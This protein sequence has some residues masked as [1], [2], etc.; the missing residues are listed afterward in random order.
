FLPT[1]CS[2]SLPKVRGGGPSSAAPAPAQPV[3]IPSSPLKVQEI[4]PE[5]TTR[6]ITKCSRKRLPETTPGPRKKAKV[7][8]RHKSHHEVESLKIQAVKGKGST[9]PVDEA[10]TPRSRRPKLVRELCNAQ[11]GVDG[12]DYHVVRMSS[13]L[14]HDTDAPLELAYLR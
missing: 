5:E 13:L 7:T 8:G 6:K 11:L 12:R 2:V 4:R 3:V 10:S 1:C 9:S 14:E